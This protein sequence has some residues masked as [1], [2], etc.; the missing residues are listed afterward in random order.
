M[1]ARILV[2]ED[3]STNMELMVYLLTAFGYT[4]LSAYDGTSGVE[5]AR[6]HLPDLIVCDVHLPKLDGYGVVRALKD[7]PATA[8]S[9]RPTASRASRWCAPNGPTSS[10]PTS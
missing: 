9:R 1:S 7:D 5:R 4:P 2:I 10:S 8:W 6:E 3:N